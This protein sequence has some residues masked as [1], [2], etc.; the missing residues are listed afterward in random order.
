MTSRWNIPEFFAPLPLAAV[1]LL[2][3]ND[4]IL[5]AQY[6]NAVTGK[7]S[8]VAICFFLPLFTSAGLGVLGMR[9]LMHRLAVGC[10][11]AG[12]VFSMLEM[13][14]AAVRLFCSAMPAVSSTLW[15]GHGCHMTSDATDLLCLL[16]IPLAFIYGCRRAPAQAMSAR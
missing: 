11:I 6:G 2:A 8:D 7:L 9:N 5:K 3:L 10:V 4:H 1:A 14:P 16:L 12:T 15:A 13:W